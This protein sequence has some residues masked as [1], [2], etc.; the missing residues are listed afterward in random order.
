MGRRMPIQ[1]QIYNIKRWLRR[2]G[3]EPDLI[4]VEA[5]VDSTLSYRENLKIVKEAIAG[6]TGIPADVKE[7]MLRSAHELHTT[8]SPRSQLLDERFRA[9]RTVD[10][11]EASVEDIED[12]MEHPDKMDIYGIDASS[13]SKPVRRRSR[14]GSRKSRSIIDRIKRA[15]RG[16]SGKR[17]KRKR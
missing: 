7:Q 9:R 3:Y 14:K 2:H 8:R 16:G 10:P 6:M 4:D 11:R 13:F 17:S 15:L 5:L 12:W 1:L